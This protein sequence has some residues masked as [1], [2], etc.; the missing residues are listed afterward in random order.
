MALLLRLSSILGFDLTKS[1]NLSDDLSSQLMELVISLRQK[2]REEKN[3]VMSDFI[4][5]EL[6]KLNIVLK[7]QKDKPTIW[8]IQD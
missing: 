1:E 8:S 2:S 7:D 3:W 4:R 6:A 5:D